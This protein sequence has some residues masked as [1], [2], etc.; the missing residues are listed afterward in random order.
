[1]DTP[2]HDVAQRP[3]LIHL[4]GGLR[5]RLLPQ[6][7]SSQAAALIRVHAGAHDAPTA[8]P[9][10][11]HFL[12]HLL[13]LGSERYPLEQSLMPFVQ[14]C[15]GQLNA[16]TR[17]RHTDFFFQLPADLLEQG[18]LRLID[19]LAHPL[20]DPAA[21]LREREVLQA[22]YLARAQDSETLCDAALGSVLEV[23]HPFGG[24]HAGNR[25]SLPVENDQFQQALHRY[26]RRFY[27]AGQIEL[28]LAGP[29]TAAELQRLSELA[30]RNLPCAAAV[31]RTPPPL[32]ASPS[33]LDVQIPN[34]TPGLHLCFMLD[35][36]PENSAAALDYL[37]VWISSEMP[38]SLLEYL[39]SDGL[40]QAL[41][42]REPYRYTNQAVV[43]VALQLTE[44]GQAQPEEIVA[45]VLGWLRFFA[46]EGCGQEGH[47]QYGRIRHRSLLGSAPLEQLRYWVEPAAWSAASEAEPLKHVFSA[48]MKQMIRYEPIVLVTSTEEH[49]ALASSGFPVHALRHTPRH[50]EPC[51]L[52]W[53][54]PEPNTWL[55]P[56]PFLKRSS[57]AG[58]PALHR[59]DAAYP[60]GQGALYLRWR[61]AAR[62]PV[63]LW[64]A[65]WS[66]L[67]PCSWAAKQAGVTLRF[68]ELGDSW[69]L[70]LTGFA[71]AFPIMVED[72]GALLHQLPPQAFAEGIRLAG[73]A[74]QLSGD[75]MLIRQ[76]IRQLPR[77]LGQCDS[78]YEEK[79]LRLDQ[80]A[81]QQHWRTAHRDGLIVGL[82]GDLADALAE[83]VKAMP[84]LPGDASRS[85]GA[86]RPVIGRRWQD[87]G[88]RAADTAVLLFCS[89]PDPK[90]ATEAG[91]R[92][93]A[94]LMEG[95]FFRRLR[96]ELQLGYAVFCGFRQVA[97]R[98]GML[99]AV[100]SPSASAAEILAHVEIFL[101][102]FSRKLAV[103]SPERLEQEALALSSLHLDNQ[104]AACM[105]RT[106]QNHLAGLLADHPE[107]VAAALRKLQLT[108]LQQQLQ[109]LR[110]AEDG[111]LVLANTP[112]PSEWAQTVRENRPRCSPPR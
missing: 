30:G 6:R 32:R 28:L 94:R 96:G 52:G 85:K 108:D 81:L 11:A 16:S 102:D 76:L 106:W 77:Q 70:S 51:S 47:E 71:G 44:R 22:E 103:F 1:M 53:R 109:A 18:L 69:Y 31:E 26:H 13:F 65:L 4:P 61:F 9:G 41:R 82:A 36:L 56:R 59:L 42:W 49:P 74:G 64:H 34:G 66:A 112:P 55:N 8:Y 68:E 78:G 110:D 104:P 50:I 2:E 46:Q 24:F 54:L 87:V 45:R 89:L 57:A 86:I 25:D 72:I 12:E 73:E 93:L 80:A 79:E 101:A 107:R 75:E 7:R 5:I 19:M 37:A 35:D 63:A 83:A 100:Q 33:W 99:F 90:P 92:L 97:G 111:R 14:G 23:A 95:D 98:A 40:C 27:H 67:Q 3:E 17:E 15:G 91:W 88:L 38:G 21:Q 84:G 29:Q 60:N 43:T 39:R 105:E 48:L 10:L 62:P 58:E 20:L